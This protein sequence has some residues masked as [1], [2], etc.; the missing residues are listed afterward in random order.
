[1]NVIFNISVF[2][3][4]CAV[5]F[6]ILM[7]ICDS[8]KKLIQPENEV[9]KMEDNKLAFSMYQADSAFAMQ[10]AS[11]VWSRYTGFIIIDGFL[12]TA[13]V[14]LC[15]KADANAIVTG[16]IY[17]AV[18]LAGLL[19][20]MAWHIINYSGWCNQYLWFH[21]ATT[22]IPKD[23]I[24][25]LIEFFTEKKNLKKF[26]RIYQIAQV[27]P[28][29]FFVGSVASFHKGITIMQKNLQSDS[30]DSV[31]ITLCV[32]LACIVIAFTIERIEL[33]SVG[34]KESNR[35]VA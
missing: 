10:E 22:H 29:L 24:S 1:M 31:F 12:V 26:G 32:V 27:L 5:V 9:K 17:L 8:R 6:M 4:L 11:L 2:L 30:H 16:Y 13:F 34:I 28:V 20:N 21:Y 7:I 25:S 18:G 35:N 3:L 33:A 15:M 19:I 23:N 14:E